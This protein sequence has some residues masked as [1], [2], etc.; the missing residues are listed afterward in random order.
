[1]AQV[2]ARAVAPMGMMRHLQP[3]LANLLAQRRHTVDA[4]GTIFESE[5]V[6]RHRRMAT[7]DGANSTAASSESL[8][9]AAL[10]DSSGN[11]PRA[12]FLPPGGEGLV[13][14]RAIELESSIL[15]RSA[16]SFSCGCAATPRGYSSARAVGAATP[17]GSSSARHR[18]LL[19]MELDTLET[20]FS[21]ELC[22]LPLQE[23]KNQSANFLELV[24]GCCR[25]P[26]TRIAASGWRFFME[27]S[28]CQK[29]RD[30]LLARSFCDLESTVLS[31]LHTAVTRNSTSAEGSTRRALVGYAAEFLV[32]LSTGRFGNADIDA[33]SQVL[34]AGD[35]VLLRDMCA[36]ICEELREQP[37]GGTHASTMLML[38]EHIADGGIACSRAAAVTLQSVAHGAESFLDATRSCS[39]QECRIS[40]LCAAGQLAIGAARSA[41]ASERQVAMDV[42]DELLS[43]VRHDLSMQ[44]YQ[45]VHVVRV[46]R[47]LVDVLLQSTFTTSEC[48][49]QVASF[50]IPATNVTTNDVVLLW[51][52]LLL[53]PNALQVDPQTVDH[54]LSKRL[55]LGCGDA[56]LIDRLS[57]CCLPLGSLVKEDEEE[58]EARRHSLA[59][60][61]HI[62]ST[63]EDMMAK[64][65]RNVS[66]FEQVGSWPVSDLFATAFAYSGHDRHQA[67]ASAQCGVPAK[68]ERPQ[69]NGAPAPAPLC[70]LLRSDGP[71]TMLWMALHLWFPYDGA[72]PTGATDGGSDPSLSGIARRAFPMVSTA[73]R[74]MESASSSNVGFDGTPY[75]NYLLRWYTSGAGAVVQPE[76]FFPAVCTPCGH[77]LKRL[78]TGNT[79]PELLCQAVAVS[80]DRCRAAHSDDTMD[81]LWRLVSGPSKGLYHALERFFMALCM[82]NSQEG[83]DWCSLVAECLSA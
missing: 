59:L 47:T 52:V 68:A 60:L 72:A 75:R 10:L 29:F 14:D 63:S 22:M 18:E 83:S 54:A 61:V 23:F 12:A 1:L 30:L 7:T 58:G 38:V 49:A 24:R 37:Q 78:S 16:T 5:P 25:S 6:Q 46:I 21:T 42:L 2:C 48:R 77:V 64:F 36:K 69:D 13:K 11:L 67:A 20:G 65:L 41:V 82:E 31:V 15:R 4:D 70:F 71:P 66:A 34:L 33:A 74:K 8:A 3:E 32:A 73:L 53:N 9:A 44:C 39:G 26:D 79:A 50:G 80:L 55:I 28:S 56:G 76:V 17:R 35:G 51:W 62:A 81:N 19:G 27:I 57:R 40:L 43:R 45:Y